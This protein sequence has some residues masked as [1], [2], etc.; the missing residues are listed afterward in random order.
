MLD[1]Q[2]FGQLWSRETYVREL[3]SPNSEILIVQ[4]AS[5]GDRTS[6]PCDPCHPSR[7]LP[8]QTPEHTTE[9]ATPE[10]IA[11]GYGC[12]WSILDE[13]HITILGVH[14]QHRRQGWGEVLMYGLLAVASQRG[15]TRA[16][17][18]VSCQNQAAIALYEKFGFRHAGLR[19]G[20]YSN[21][22]DA[23]ILWKSGLQHPNFVQDLARW[24][25]QIHTKAS[26]SGWH[27]AIASVPT[28]SVQTPEPSEGHPPLALD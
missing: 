9:I 18:E 8:S 21:G 22:D 12:V 11:I 13:A 4:P 19:K 28:S 16:T 15:L 7:R 2:C 25:A 5:H 14:P 3:D 23:A 17:L 10:P 27:L 20:Y 24:E 26:R 6:D 1:R